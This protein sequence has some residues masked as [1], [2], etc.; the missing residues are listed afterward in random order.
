MRKGQLK[1]EKRIVAFIDIL[2]FKE[3][4]K[5]SEFD[6]AKI[7]LLHEVL[8]YLKGWEVPKMW[9]LKLVEIEEDAQKKGVEN[10]DISGRTN[11][12]SFSDSIV[13]SVKVDDN[14]NEMASTL[15]VNLA[16]IG[17]IMM[18]KGI[19][20]RGGLTIGNIF[21]KENGTVF[22]QGL[23]E[24]YQ[25]ESKSAKYPRIILSDK[26]IREL[27]YPLEAKR[28]RYPY[29]QY[30]DR[31]DDGSVGFH[32]MIYYQV[33]DSWPEIT[34]KKKRESLD[35]IRRTIIGGLDSSFENPDVFEKYKWLKE[36]YNQLIILSDFDFKTKTK[37]N[38]KQKIREVNE[39][40][41]GQNVHFNYTDQF[42]AN[43]LKNKK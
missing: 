2:G 40:I 13:V 26:L 34:A 30:L 6:V 29:H 22:G 39:D 9:G 8:D 24:A 25:L 1:Y 27:N 36:Q 17:A 31:F 12:T 3:I 16:Y 38:I 11:T 32:Q 33:V 43:H 28:D 10:F 7:E 5:Q 14:I 21:H 41:P 35:N 42:Y 20:F 23:I 18:E 4:V 19:L 15:I 37:E